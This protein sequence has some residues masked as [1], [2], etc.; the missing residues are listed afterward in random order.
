MARNVD[1]FINIYNLLGIKIIK[2][3][4]PNDLKK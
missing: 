3:N 2:I 1:A 4:N